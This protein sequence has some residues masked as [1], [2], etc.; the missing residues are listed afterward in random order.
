MITNFGLGE[1]LGVQ[2]FVPAQHKD[3]WFNKSW[4]ADE[5]GVLA[6]AW[7]KIMHN[8]Q[9]SS[10]SCFRCWY[11]IWL[12][13][14]RD[15]WN[16]RMGLFLQHLRSSTWLV[17]SLMTHRCVIFAHMFANYIC[18]NIMSMVKMQ[19]LMLFCSWQAKPAKRGSANVSF[20]DLSKVGQPSI[21]RRR[22]ICSHCIKK[23]KQQWN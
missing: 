19:C 1:L 13:S 20:G 18:R 21:S 15:V 8:Q 17:G 16:V 11:C 14:L 3:T 10:T 23:I 6:Q 12:I 7:N 2:C 5:S 4:W 9:L 22:N